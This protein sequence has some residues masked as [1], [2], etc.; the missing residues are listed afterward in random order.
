MKL[1]NVIS[2]YRT[3]LTDEISPVPVATYRILF[4]VIALTNAFFLWPDR[5]AW[6]SDAGVLP[7][8]LGQSLIGTDRLNLF[9][10]FGASVPVV[11][12]VFYVHVVSALGIFL[13]L[14]TRV[15]TICFYLTLASFHHRNLFII[16]S[17]DTLLRLMAFW[18]VFAP[19]SEVLS[20]DS[21]FRGYSKRKVSGFAVRMMQLQLC[22][23][24]F[25]SFYWKATG[26]SWLNGTAVHLVGELDQFARFPLPLFLNTVWGSC[27]LTWTTLL[28]EGL[29]PFA[30]W[31]EETRLWMLGAAVILHAGLEYSLN[32][33]LFQFVITSVFVLFLKEEELVRP[34]RFLRRRLSQLP[35]YRLDQTTSTQSDL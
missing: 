21:F 25:V 19:S 35:A 2:G 5:L 30:V 1:K 9:N 34:L 20:L 7:L 28:V 32:V 11:E 15:S 14:F 23:L 33:Q 8:Q 16:H 12:L 10:L 18:M 22:L 3:F 31:F 13:G 29:F 6:F 24:Y 17:G 26:P 4:G 27:F